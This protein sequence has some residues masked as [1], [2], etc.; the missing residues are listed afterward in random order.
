MTSAVR[1]RFVVSGASL[2]TLLFCAHF[3]ND[4][5]SGTLAAL[6]PTLQVRFG[7]SEVM[8]AAF[9]AM[10]SFSSS[11]LQPLFGA[12]ADRFG[13]RVVAAF[14]VITTSSILSLMSVTPSA[15]LLLPFLFVG[16]LGSAAF[17]PAGSSLARSA[18][19]RNRGLAMAVFSAG[20]TFGM[21]MGPLIIGWF[22]INEWLSFTPWLM[23]PGIVFG[24]LIYVLV[25]AQLRDP[26]TQRSKLFDVELFKGPVGQLCAAGILRSISWTAII[27]G[28]PLWLVHARGLGPT[29]PTLFLTITTFTLSGALGGI[30]VGMIERR[31]SRQALV[32]GS[33]LLAIVPLGLMLVSTPGSV[34]YFVLVALAG[35]LVNGGLPIM[36]VAAQDMAPHAIATASGMMMGLTWGAAGVIYLG[37]GALQE[38]IG[39]DAAM[40]LSILPLLP[41]ALIA[42]VVMRRHPTA[43][44]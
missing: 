27:N 37:I 38:A 5:F 3:F 44:A 35:M 15:W 31:F 14:G 4:F 39:L 16:G 43:A 41:G 1:S 20:G 34:L 21:A 10:L 17:H 25:P 24:I 19:T 23:V 33:M 36:V 18:V 7:A 13:R 22:L 2:T 9:V 26:A 42:Y 29:S 8:L 28:A 6:L 11:M 30:L 40:V 12:V 32:T